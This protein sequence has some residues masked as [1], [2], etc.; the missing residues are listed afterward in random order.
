M[1]SGQH[2]TSEN[3]FLKKIEKGKKHVVYHFEYEGET[4]FTQ[5]STGTYDASKGRLYSKQCKSQ[6]EAQI[7]CLDR[8]TEKLS[9]G[10]QFYLDGK[11][12]SLA[13]IEKALE[14]KRK[15]LLKQLDSPRSPLKSQ[16]SNSLKRKLYKNLETPRTPKKAKRK[17]ERKISSE[18]K[19]TPLSKI[20][21]SIKREI[22]SEPVKRK[23]F[24]AI[25]EQ[26]SVSRELFPP[27]IDFA[28]QT[29]TPES[30]EQDLEEPTY[31]YNHSLDSSQG[32]DS[33][34]INNSFQEHLDQKEELENEKKRILEEIKQFEQEKENLKIARENLEKERIEF[35]IHIKDFE[36][37]QNMYH[38]K[39]EELVKNTL[40]LQNKQKELEEKM[41]QVL[42]YEKQLN[43]GLK[44]IELFEIEK[45]EIEKEMLKKELEVKESYQ[46]IEQERKKIE[47]SYMKITI[48]ENE[49]QE[50]LTQNLE[51]KKNL[52]LKEKETEE[53]F[54][55]ELDKIE[56][57]NQEILD[58]ENH[59][60]Q[61]EL[62]LQQREQEIYLQGE[63]LKLKKDKILIASKD[64]CK[65]IEEI[66]IDQ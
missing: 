34:D 63:N 9:Q 35:S 5:R 37:F 55:K 11:K 12:K 18:R 17:T 16:Q 38:K 47:E 31:F 23:K 52:E 46:I 26:T 57:R 43:E 25:E 50:I 2:L 39:D 3:S 48:K 7:I 27:S 65:I 6:I 41:I 15:N 33:L 40:I 54:K 62:I 44:R 19:I 56:K 4:L 21:R 13:M 42:E 20:P 28:E 45:K 8:I 10:F 53:Y 14:T 61:R 29:F 58:F 32:G 36:V 22:R 59:L 51:M 66:N 49:N 1:I 60:K 64:F 30:K 24:K